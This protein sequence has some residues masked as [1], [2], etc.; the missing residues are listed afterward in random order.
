M[1][2]HRTPEEHQA[3]PPAGWT[4]RKAG[5]RS[6]QL[7]SSGGGVLDT[8]TTRTE[9]LAARESGWLVSLYQ[10][11]GRWFAGLPVA[12]WR[13]YADIAAERARREERTRV[14]AAPQ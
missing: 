4:V 9:A 14:S 8:F 11:E 12:N 6:W 13:P 5:A 3:D 7:M 1:S 10:K 2:L